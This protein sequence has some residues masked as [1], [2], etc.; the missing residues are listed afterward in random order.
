LKGRFLDTTLSLK[1][2]SLLRPMGR[3]GDR[4]PVRLEGDEKLGVLSRHV[5]PLDHLGLLDESLELGDRQAVHLALLLLG[6][7]LGL[8]LLLRLLLLV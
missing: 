3:N 1:I 8:F 2:I 6:Q 4:V 5:R 7:M